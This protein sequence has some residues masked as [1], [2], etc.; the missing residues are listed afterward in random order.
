MGL[1]ED[2]IVIARDAVNDFRTEVLRRMD[3]TRKTY[4]GRLTK[5][6]AINLL[7]SLL[8]MVR[9]IPLPGDE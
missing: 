9:Q 5:E 7:D 1:T 6:I 3:I 8:V 2:E 4:E